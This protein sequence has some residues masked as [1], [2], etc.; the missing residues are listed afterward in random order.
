MPFSATNFR[1][2]IPV[3]FKMA[4][5]PVGTTFRTTEIATGEFSLWRFFIHFVPGP[6]TNKRRIEPVITNSCKSYYYTI[7][8][9]TL[10][11]VAFHT[12]GE[13]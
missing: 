3:V 7:A 9:K 13:I 5:V 10:A 1:E 2:V 8:F 4:A 12:A 11:N 6:I